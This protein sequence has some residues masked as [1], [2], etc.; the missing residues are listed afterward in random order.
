MAV[1]SPLSK[2]LREA[3]GAEAAEDLVTRLDEARFQRDEFRA[4]VRAD[5]AEFRQEILAAIHD[6]EIRMVERIHKVQLDLGETLGA[7]LQALDRRIGD[8]KADLMKW[9]FAFWI[10]AVAAIAALA[11]VLR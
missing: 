7:Q 4:S 11:G 2:K 1:P 3:L 10:G 9:S 5:F 6:S 8:V